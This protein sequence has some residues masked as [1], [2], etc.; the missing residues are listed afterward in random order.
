RARRVAGISDVHFAVREIPNQPGINGA[1]RELA[2]L[3]SS[4]RARLFLKNPLELWR[5]ERG[6]DHQAGFSANERFQTPLLHSVAHGGGPTVLPNDGVPDRIARGAI[7]NN[8]CLALI[9]N[10]NGGDIS[11]AE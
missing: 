2:C 5:A 7:P 9:S 8:R 6:V 3:R 4:A 10:A 11:R 1:E